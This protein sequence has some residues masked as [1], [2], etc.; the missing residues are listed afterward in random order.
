MRRHDVENFPKYFKYY[1]GKLHLMLDEITK[2]L[3]FR[4]EPYAPILQV[5]MTG[6]LRYADVIPYNLKWLPKDRKGNTVDESKKAR[7]DPALVWTE[8]RWI[9]CR[10]MAGDDLCQV[11]FYKLATFIW[12]AN[13]IKGDMM[14]YRQNQVITTIFKYDNRWEFLDKTNSP[15]TVETWDGRVRAMMQSDY[16]NRMFLEICLLGPLAALYGREVQQL[17]M[18]PETP[19]KISM[20]DFHHSVEMG[21]ASIKQQALRSSAQQQRP[22]DT[23]TQGESDRYS[24][25]SLRTRSPGAHSP[26]QPRR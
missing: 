21:R 23:E 3:S 8:D 18:A 4:P 22:Y 10:R 16:V 19:D 14:K 25:S 9:F 24:Q 17:L 6:R 12:G 2:G 20:D 11:L 5:N 1:G 13:Q 15:L 7:F 26:R